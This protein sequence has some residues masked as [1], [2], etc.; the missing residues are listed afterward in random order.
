MDAILQDLRFAIRGL[1][2][3]PGFTA[4]A[5]LTLA[6]GIGANT[7]IF[8]LINAVA[9]RPLPVRNPEELV[10]VRIVGGNQG[11]GVN[12]GRYS[13]LTLPVWH[14]I[15]AHQQALS[16]AFAWGT[17]ELRVGERSDL[18]PAGGI[19]VS[20]EFFRVL[21]VQ[22][23]RG[24]LLD[25]ADEALPCPASRAVVSYAYWQ[26]EMGGREIDRD[27]RLRVNLELVD[28]IGVTP[29]EFFG[30]AVGESFD[31]ALPLC[32]Q[33]EYY[34][35]L[36]N[37]AVMG[38]LRPG[39][40]IERASAHLNAL[41]VGIF[42]V[43]APTGYSPARI[44]RFKSFRLA[45]YPASTGVS[46]LRT[47]YD[48]SLHLLLAITALVLLI[49]CA[50][51]ANLMLARASARAREVAVRIALG[52]S[53]MAIVRQFLAESC[54]LAAIGA[55]F[56]VGLAHILGRA[57]LWALSTESGSP[58][59]SLAT[60]WYVLLFAS[61]VAFITCVIF[62]LAPAARATRIQPAMAIRTGGR[63]MTSGHER[64]SLQRLMVTMQI[65]ISLVMLV[66]ALLFVRS[67]RNLMTFDPGIRQEGI[68]VAIFRFGE[69]RVAA[70]RW[71]DFKRELLAE[72][73]STPGVMSAGTTTHVPLLGGSWEHGVHVGANQG[74]AKFTW[75]SPGY[76]DT[77]GIRLLQGRDFTLRD[78]QASARVAIVNQEFVRRMVVNANPIGQILR[79][80][81]EPNYPTTSYEIVGVIPNT[82][83]N[84]LRGETPPMVFAPDS[85][86]PAQGP[87]TPMIIY[88]S[89]APEVAITRVRQR[90]RQR[91][92]EV[93]SEF[94]VFR[95]QIRSRLVRER[96]LAM[97]AG[98]F[99]VLAVLLTV[100]GLY[101]M[102]SYLVTQRRP[103]I[104]VRLALGAHWRHVVGMVMGEAGWLLIIG[105]VVG[106][107]FSLLAG[108]TAATLL[109]GL[110]PNDPLTLAGACLLLAITAAAASFLPARRAARMDPAQ[111]LRDA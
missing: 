1:I 78:T 106:A 107:V 21:G 11:F 99:G 72:V 18:R 91:Y 22:P 7:A 92:P 50:N 94:S 79:T 32:Q 51:L 73:K 76:F 64:Q 16:G 81:P 20:G 13:Q 67:F 52:A 46:A 63:G 47:Q 97:L 66:A 27:T 93:L 34:R 68:T 101:G 17:R 28:V 62:G 3:T 5:V 42:E 96:L 75:I 56:A 69:S 95:T 57:L 55:V 104:G 23:W 37:I 39:W 111:V 15:R 83:Y 58:T 65:A 9:L 86:F 8:Q 38:R 53:R 54:L 105:I 59:L 10:E 109:F 80:N 31:I 71:V 60:D 48:T 30:I 49:A 12:P 29:P 103:E 2:R 24:G 108:R 25:A 88:S 70:E 36:F 102:L 61:L 26:R 85:Q 84:D 45:A 98:F 4:V 44:E 110:K 40:T 41:S 74:S 14:E 33:K 82:Q 90:I 43:M 89:V 6:L 100:V 77:L 35:N 87:G 19:V